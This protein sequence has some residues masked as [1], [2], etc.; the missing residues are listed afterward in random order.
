M[1]VRSVR[2]RRD[3][4]PETRVDDHRRHCDGR[5][6]FVKPLMDFMQ[7]TCSCGVKVLDVPFVFAD[8]GSA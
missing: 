2:F 8:D 4:H 5:W 3:G 1:T 7:F 6:V